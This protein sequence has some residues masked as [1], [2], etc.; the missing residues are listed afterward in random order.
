MNIR[1][2]NDGEI[3]VVDDDEMELMLAQRYVERSKLT[4]P[5]I[6][7]SSGQQVLDHLELVAA[8]NHKV[9][10]LIM[11]DVRMPMLDGFEVVEKIRAIDQFESI[12]VIMMFSNSD[13][14]SDIRRSKEVGANAYKV[15][16]G[17]GE[18]FIAFLNSLV[19]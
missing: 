7:F 16:P 8:G 2:T 11:M 13:S 4:N 6:T 19:D 9:P 18:E 1:I 15:K 17:G 12:P 3:I 10:A 14:E 5:L